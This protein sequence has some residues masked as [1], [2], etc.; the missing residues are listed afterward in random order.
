[1]SY[2]YQF[3]LERSQN[4]KFRYN[5]QIC[6]I[7]ANMSSYRSQ[8]EQIQQQKANK[9][10]K[11]L[12]TAAVVAVI[13]IVALLVIYFF[14][15]RA[16]AGPSVG[17]PE[18]PVKVDM[19]SNYKCSYCVSFTREN[20]DDFIKNYV[21]TGKVYLTYHIFPFTDDDGQVAA[22]ATYCA[23]DQNKFWEYKKQVF[24]NV[25][26]SGALADSSLDTYAQ[27]VGLDMAQFQQC[28]SSDE[29]TSTINEVRQYA[30]MNGVSGTPTFIV[31]GTLVYAGE[32]E[33]TVE[34]A[35]AEAGN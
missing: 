20:E 32:L 5:K 1:M 19:F 7:G 13:I 11:Q 16:V 6:F 9:K 28:R 21:D 35:L 4:S 12:T 2:R 33:A 18:A 10:K 31:N 34:N 29:H 25:G 23:A 3:R 15:R 17:D 27:N 14:P 30:Q 24:E 8:R 22:E 26:F